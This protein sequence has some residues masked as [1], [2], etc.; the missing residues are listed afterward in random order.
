MNNETNRFRHKLNLQLFAEDPAPTDDPQNPP[1]EPTDPPK[2]FTQAEL[3]D[4]IAKRIERER[5]KYGDYDD[6][7]AKL[8][9][10]QSAE[11]ERKRGELTEVERIKADLE[12]ES[13]AKQTLESELS[14]LRE[15]V[16]QERIRNAFISAATTA[17][18]AYIDD[19]WALADKA[20]ISVGDDGNVTGVDDVIKAL[21]ESKPFLV[22]L[23]PTQPRTIGG[24][25]DNPPPAQKTAEQL[26]KEAAEK[27]KKSGK[28]E[29]QASYAKLK[30]ELGL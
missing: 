9:E 5:K 11:D 10:L 28:I 21:V 30:R 23:K 20:G 19:A 24:A 4:V 13:G 16:K 8:A 14:S 26:L 15:S 7:K 3:D 18:I 25:T 1:A 2:T 22:E 6:I 29:D 17:K 12:R 27:A